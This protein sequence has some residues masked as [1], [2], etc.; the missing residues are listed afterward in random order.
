MRLQSMPGLGF[1]V[2]DGLGHGGHNALTMAC[3]ALSVL[4]IAAHHAVTTPDTK[5]PASEGKAWLSRQLR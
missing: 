5:S 3:N 1:S 2:H 4:T